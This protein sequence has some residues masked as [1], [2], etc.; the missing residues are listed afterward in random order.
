LR[1]RLETDGGF[2]AEELWGELELELKVSRMRVKVFVM[3]VQ[4][5]Q[6]LMVPGPRRIGDQVLDVMV[7]VVVQPSFDVLD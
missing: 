1:E 2:G 6:L 3:F 4:A 7:R 5:V